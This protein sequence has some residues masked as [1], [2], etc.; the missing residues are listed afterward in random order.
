MRKKHAIV[1][2][3]MTICMA[4][5]AFAGCGPAGIKSSTGETQQNS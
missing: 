2:A 4:L 5:T 1:A 3:G